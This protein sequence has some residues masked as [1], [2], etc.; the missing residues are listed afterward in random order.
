MLKV[1]LI[2]PWWIYKAILMNSDGVS[3]CL[4]SWVNKF[5]HIIYLAVCKGGRRI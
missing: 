4:V 3:V 1:S 5:I 2:Y